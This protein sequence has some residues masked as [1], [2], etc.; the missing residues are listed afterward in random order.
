MGRLLRIAILLVLVLAAKSAFAAGGACPTGVPVTGS[1]CYFVAANGSDSNSGTSE[2]S[3]WLHAPGMPNCAKTCLSVWNSTLPAGTGIILRGGDTWHF[4]INND[5]SGNPASGG[6]W[7]F[8]AG[9][10]P[11]G[12]SLSSPIYVGVDQNW[13]SG[14]SWARPTLTA[15]N[16]LC[17]ASTIGS[18][19]FSGSYPGGFYYVNSCAYQIPGG[20]NNFLELGA[21]RFY[22]IDNLEMT[23]LCSSQAGQPSHT[24]DYFSYGGASGP[25]EFI[26]LY[27]H[28]ATHTRF[29]GLNGSGSC[30][31]STVCFDSKVFEGSTLNDPG[32]IIKNVVV[33]FS[34]SD[35]IG[36]G[37]CYCGFYDVSDSVFRYT[38]QTVV[39]DINTFHDN[40][41]EYFFENGHSNALESVGDSGNTTVYNNIFRHMETTGGNGGVLIW[42]LPPSGATSYFFNNLAYDIGQMEYNNI[43]DS[44][45]ATGNYVYFNNTFQTTVNQ[46]IMGCQN[47]TGGTFTD[48]NNHYIT[49]SSPYVSGCSPG[50]T[51]SSKTMTNAAATAAG[52]TSSE[53]YA[54]SPTSGSSATVGTGT[55]VGTIN[56][57]LC[58]AI[59]AAGFSAAATV[60]ASD[61]TYS[62]TYDVSSHTVNC[63]AR[64][65]VARPA[66]AAWDAGA[67]QFSAAT[68]AQGPQAPTNLQAQVQ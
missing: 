13:Y 59:S 15:D 9:P 62:C 66:T 54:Y 31:S 41:Y 52:Y 6:T 46:S 28:G 17:N 24:N 8:N 45:T 51:M 68:K 34:D 33:D 32:E 39:R 11:N 7:N 67:Y 43:G 53:S 5:S 12:N 48:A 36:T 18:N 65:T 3:P 20:S 64:T 44:H 38:S 14:T 29:A 58:N 25:I 26:N 35:G 60:C 63:P 4:G 21:R 37:L 19:C 50:T 23:G 2:S 22:I 27:I 49:D 55:N 1:N 42:M 30:T 56:S 40:L 10:S 16:P 57:A 47:L 61:T